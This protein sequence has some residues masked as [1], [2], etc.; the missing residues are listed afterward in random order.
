MRIFDNTNIIRK[1]MIE[2]QIEPTTFS[3]LKFPKTVYKYRTAN[4]PFHRTIL[5]NRIVYFAAPE[6]FEDEFDCRIPE[7]YDLLTDDEIFEQYYKLLKEE[8]P[9]WDPIYLR[10]E[11]VRWCNLG[12]LKDKN[13]LI[14]IEK[15][16]WEKL[17]QRFGVLSLTPVRDNL[18]MWRKYSNNLN[19][20]CVGFISRILFKGIGGGGGISYVKDLPLINPFASPEAK[21]TALTFYKLNKWAFEKEYRLQNL[22]SHPVNSKERE[23]KVPPSAFT[24]IILGEKLSKKAKL[25][26]I[27]LAKDINPKIQINIAAR[28]N[29]QV[30]IMPIT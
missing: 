25:E 24:E 6:T 20:F 2:S 30:L 28:D 3:K 27:G 22:W 29:G 10:N 16:D 4:N 7:R 23:Y 19:G 11:V 9:S 8:N 14:N 17:N 26:I 1:A 21:R 5:S 12:L 13:R 15:M 18:S